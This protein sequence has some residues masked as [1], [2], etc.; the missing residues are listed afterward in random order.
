MLVKKLK[1]FVGSLLSVSLF[2]VS[3]VPVLA[4]LK[5]DRQQNV[6]TNGTNSLLSQLRGHD[7]YQGE[8]QLEFSDYQ[9]GTVVGQF[10]NILSVKLEDGTIFNSRIPKPY[11]YRRTNNTGANVLVIEE[12]GNYKIVDF[13]HPR[14][15][16]KLEQD[17]E[18]RR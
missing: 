16:R 12:D 9:L 5:S 13:A 11:F 18:L 2:T 3:A 7:T 15:I 4:Q 1:V 8:P 6:T 14:W 10:G 17:Y